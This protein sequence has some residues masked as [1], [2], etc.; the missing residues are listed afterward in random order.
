[1]SKRNP[2][3][4]ELPPADAGAAQLF[5]GD[6]NLQGESDYWLER[7]TPEARTYAEVTGTRT[8]LR[9]AKVEQALSWLMQGYTQRQVAAATHIGTTTLRV[10]MR[11]W[12]ADGRLN[13]LKEQLVEKFGDIVL[14]GAESIQSA[15]DEGRMSPKDVS[16]AVG[17]SADKWLA[18]MGMATAIVEHRSAEPTIEDV[19][20]MMERLPLAQVTEVATV[21]A[22]AAEPAPTTPPSDCVSDVS[23]TITQ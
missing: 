12:R 23:P 6:L 14:S 10:L 3:P 11:R 7:D 13:T 16:V 5:F 8:E 20:R 21:Q 17:I 1:M 9:A 4:D 22:P 2:E 19:R 15:I 18:L